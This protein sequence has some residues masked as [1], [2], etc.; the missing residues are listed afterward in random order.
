MRFVAK[1][2]VNCI[3]VPEVR[4]VMRS[5]GRS[6]APP[7]GGGRSNYSQ[8]IKRPNARPAPAPSGPP[9]PQG[10]PPRGPPGGS[11]RGPPPP[12]QSSLRPA[13]QAPGSVTSYDTQQGRGLLRVLLWLKYWFSSFLPANAANRWNC[14]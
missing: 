8:P 14:R 12:M 2:A 11:S 13:P 3:S 10:G 7:R 1:I 4:N 9:L 5:T 6:R